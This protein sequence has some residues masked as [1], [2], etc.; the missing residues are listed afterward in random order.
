M[1]VTIGVGSGLNTGYFEP[2]IAGGLRPDD[3][4]NVP[5]YRRPP[6]LIDVDLSPYSPALKGKKFRGRMQGIAPVAYWDRGQIEDGARSPARAWRSPTRPIRT[7]CS[8]CT[9]RARA[10]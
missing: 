7:N 5:I 1:P 10:A 4:N 6:D 8:S 9:S 2:E 3:I